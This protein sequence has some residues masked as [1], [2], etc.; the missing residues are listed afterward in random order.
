M[1][2]FIILTSLILYFNK[3]YCQI[4]TNGILWKEIHRISFDSAS[5]VAPEIVSSNDTVHIVWFGLFENAE[6]D[7]GW[8]IIY[9]RST[10][11]GNSFQ[12]QKRLIH[13]DSV[14]AYKYFGRSGKYLYVIYLALV[15]SP[16]YWSTAI[17]RSSDQ[18]RSWQPRQVIKDYWTYAVTTKD[19]F[20]FIYSGLVE[21]NKFYNAML[22]SSDYGAHWDTVRIQLAGGPNVAKLTTTNNALHLIRT[23]GFNQYEEVIYNRST[24]FGYTWTLNDTLSTDDG[25]NSQLPKIV[26]DDSTLYLTWNDQK[27]GGNF[28]GTILMRR[29]T[30]E[31]THWEEEQIISQLNTAVYNDISVEKNIVL[32]IWDNEDDTLKQLRLRSSFDYGI[33]FTE[34]EKITPNDYHAGDPTININLNTIY[35]SWWNRSNKEVYFKKGVFESLGVINYQSY[36]IDHNLS[37]NYP[38]PF[39]PQ[40]TIHYEIPYDAEVLITVYDLLGRKLSTLV[41]TRQHAGR[42]TVSF[43]GSHLSGGVYLYSLTSGTFTQTRKMILLK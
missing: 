25:Q 11:G 29:S 1:K 26:S 43:D 30:D 42:Y 41:D 34:S 39:N 8:G 15:D 9:S 17:I 2:L 3:S 5:S 6:P 38:N 16:T 20:I 21:N 32:I 31:G 4:E 33:T 37:Q 27:Y 10:D 14:S 24:D 18:G 23:I 35:C 12:S 40:T 13:P 7:S 22:I 19:S 36:N 28:S